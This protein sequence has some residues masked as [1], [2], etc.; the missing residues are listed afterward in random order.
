M[1]GIG[2]Q[3]FRMAMYATYQFCKSILHIVSVDFHINI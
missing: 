3:I 2:E 1:V